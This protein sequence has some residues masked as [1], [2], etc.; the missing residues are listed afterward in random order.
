MSANAIDLVRVISPDTET[1]LAAIVDM[2]EAREVPCFVSSPR[3]GAG[4]GGVS[5]RV[6]KPR[7]ILVPAARLTEALALIGALQGTP[8]AHGRAAPKPFSGRLRALV[9]FFTRGTPRR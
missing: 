1:E 3:P 7:T 5:G 2:L 6:N 8:A 9:S 4:R